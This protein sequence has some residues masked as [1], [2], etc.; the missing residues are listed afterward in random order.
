[1]SGEGEASAPPDSA[2]VIL[3]VTND[4]NLPSDALQANGEAVRSVIEVFRS[5]GIEARGI[6]TTA[7]VLQPRYELSQSQSRDKITG[8][9]AS[10]QIKVQVRDLGG[11]GRLL[12]QAVAVGGNE[13]Q[14][15]NIT[16][17]DRGR[18]INQARVKALE[19]A[20]AKAALYAGAAHLKLGS[21]ISLTEERDSPAPRVPAGRAAAADP[22][23]VPLASGELVLRVRVHAAWKIVD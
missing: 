15:L 3:V 11:L 23:P 16:V 7:L 17:A 4:G 22:G 19:D 12:N 14:R 18:L 5:S 21:I 9:T 6:Q 13:I 8:Y 2:V 1:M 10:H 20:Q